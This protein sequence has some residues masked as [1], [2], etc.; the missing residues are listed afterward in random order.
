MRD[1]LERVVPFDGKHVVVLARQIPPTRSWLQWAVRTLDQAETV[2]FQE[3]E[4]TPTANL[5]VSMA[6]FTPEKGMPFPAEWTSLK[7]VREADK[8]FALKSLFLDIDVGDDKPYRFP[9]KHAPRWTNF[10]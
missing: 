2:L 5:Y 6:S 9:R 4:A 8:A 10:S 3:L 1:Y 7:G